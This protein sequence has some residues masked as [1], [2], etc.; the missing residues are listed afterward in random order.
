M[1]PGESVTDGS[2][3]SS[4]SRVADMCFVSHLMTG[5]AILEQS[6]GKLPGVQCHVCWGW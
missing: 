3:E 4:D 6:K 5:I 2:I 1:V